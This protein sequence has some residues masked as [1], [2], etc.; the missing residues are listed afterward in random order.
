M[1]RTIGLRGSLLATVLVFA[2]ISGA[3]FGERGDS[4][5]STSL[6]LTSVSPLDLV[7]ASLSEANT[8]L[9]RYDVMTRGIEEQVGELFNAVNRGE[10]GRVVLVEV[11]RITREVNFIEAGFIQV[12]MDLDAVEK[13]LRRFYE[14]GSLSVSRHVEPH[15]QSEVIKA[16]W[17]ELQDLWSALNRGFDN[18]DS[19]RADLHS[20]SSTI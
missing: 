18:V 8:D 12:G 2:C 20:L 13:I 16:L 14:P 5:S 3:V 9:R 1:E 15:E 11:F 19:I 7:K 4:I 10:D 6:T 17:G